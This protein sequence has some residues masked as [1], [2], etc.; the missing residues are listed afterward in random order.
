MKVTMF[1]LMP[2]REL[3]DD[4]TKR[5]SS[6]W[7]EPEFHDLATPEQAG[8]FYNE[9]LDELIFAARAGLDGVCVNE[10]HQNAYGFFVN[11]NIMGGVLARATNE[12]ALET[13]IIQMGATLP[14]SQP[15]IRVAEEYAVIDC[16]SGGRLVAGLPLGSAMDVNCTYGVKPITQR[17]RYYEAHDLVLKAWASKEP[18]QFNG[19]YTKLPYVNLW[20]RPVQQPPPVWIPGVGS[21]ST[22]E[23]TAKHNHCYC[24]L[25]FFGADSAVAGMNGFWELGDS[26]GLDRNPYRAGFLQTV[27]VAETDEQAEKLFGKHVEYFYHNGQHHDPR[28]FMPP[29]HQDYLSLEKALRS[30][31]HLRFTKLVDNIKKMKYKD[32]VEKGFVIA[33]SPE[34]VREQIT[35]AMKKLNVG[36]LMA[37]LH[38]GSMPHDLTLQNIDLFAREVYPEVK[39]LFADDGW[40][41][42]WW[43]E[44]LG[45]TPAA[46]RRGHNGH[47]TTVTSAAAGTLSA[48]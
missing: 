21:Y 39:K 48:P 8:R 29:G 20:P 15:P 27:C 43:P 37:L 26:L 25:S 28:Y 31:S 35:S 18:F 10:H 38:F 2:H 1:H 9:T 3:P 14:T 4:F 47:S 6:V 46:L 23:F 30:G 11:P 42:E 16:I 24:F 34:T 5:Y 41:H 19:K 32:F 36:N 40:A 22:W 45:G 44:R 7:V 33:G 13:A 12:L 17:E